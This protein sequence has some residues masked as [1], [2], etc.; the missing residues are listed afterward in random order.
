M[1]VD[2]ERHRKEIGRA[3]WTETPGNE[4]SRGPIVRASRQPGLRTPPVSR[5]YRVLR[6]C[7]A[8]AVEATAMQ[9]IGVFHGSDE[10][11][12]AS[13]RTASASLGTAHA[14]RLKAGKPI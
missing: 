7:K 12:Q 1:G 4:I 14:A 5:K 8:K 13:T 3:A 11:K 2:E 10:G 6:A 9:E